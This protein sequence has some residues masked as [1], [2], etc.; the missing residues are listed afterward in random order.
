M[1]AAPP[2]TLPPRMCCTCCTAWAYG[3]E[4]I[5]TPWSRSVNGCRRNWA[6]APTAGP[7]TPW[8]RATRRHSPANKGLRVA[9][10]NKAPAMLA[11]PSEV[12]REREALL[13]E[14]DL[15]VSGPAYRP[16]VKA[17]AWVVL[18]LLTLLVISAA[19]RVP[20]ESLDRAMTITVV[21][22]YV[23]LAIIAVAM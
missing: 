15:P 7:A 10:W 5:S 8:L 17:A 11:L 21:F 12:A 1:R 6:D 3:R 4:W 20:P 13:D 16:I 2:A 19:L 14:L 18:A 22:C 23:G 9:F